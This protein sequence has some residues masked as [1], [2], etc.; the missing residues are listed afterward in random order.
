[1][2]I[3]VRTACHA[4][5]ERVRI[6]FAIAK[7]YALR[8]E[9][10][11]RRNVRARIHLFLEHPHSSREAFAF[12]IANYAAVCGMVVIMIL[13]TRDD[14]QAS[15]GAIS[16]LVVLELFLSLLFSLVLLLRLAAEDGLK[17]MLFMDSLFNW[18]D[19][20]ALVPSYIQVG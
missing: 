11:D 9:L 10:E 2:P 5:S 8:R 13:E 20:V 7:N 3:H 6:A 1:M 12:H 19:L 17:Q 16:V 18:L 14:V 4:S 15:A